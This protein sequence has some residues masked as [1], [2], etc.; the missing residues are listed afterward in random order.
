MEKYIYDNS[1]GLW[2]ELHGDYYL[3]CL[4]IP[5]M[6]FWTNE[7]FKVFIKAL[8]D[9]PIGY[10][11][12]MVMYYTGLRVGEL[13]ALTPEDIDFDRHIISV[14]KNYQRLNGKDYIYPPKTEAGYREVVMP[15]VL[16][17]L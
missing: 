7:E 9:R 11:V 6:L 5:E 15:K 3:P 16:E 2:Y 14:S 17:D 1:N 8:E 10:T 4:V 13:L 12:F